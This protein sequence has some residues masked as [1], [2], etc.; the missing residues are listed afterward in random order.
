M[1]NNKTGDVLYRT[2]GIDNWKLVVV[3]VP[4]KFAA[5]RWRS[6][7]A[8][9]AGADIHPFWISA[10]DVRGAPDSW[11]AEGIGSLAALHIISVSH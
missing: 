11:V 10:F 1:I 8:D 6:L 5:D 2:V 4:S 3:A 7:G 9:R